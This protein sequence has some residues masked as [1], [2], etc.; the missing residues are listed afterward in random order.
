MKIKLTIFFGSASFLLRLAAFVF[1]NPD[2]A[3]EH[4]DYVYDMM[5]LSEFVFVL[6]AF[7]MTYL[8]FPYTKLVAIA[9]GVMR[10]I[11]AA[12]T[13]ATV[14]ELNGLNTTDTPFETLIFCLII[15]AVGSYSQV[16]IHKWEKHRTGT[17]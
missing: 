1:N 10:L 12:T 5:A 4:K 2:V 3:P 16:K 9:R 7:I 15:L 11:L 6:A 14:K 13:F 17:F 8:I